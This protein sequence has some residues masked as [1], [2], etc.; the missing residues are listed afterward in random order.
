MLFR[1]SMGPRTV[2]WGTPDNTRALSEVAP[3]KTTFF[4]LEERKSV[5]TRV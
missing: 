2:P 1:K 5:I 4:D 3:S